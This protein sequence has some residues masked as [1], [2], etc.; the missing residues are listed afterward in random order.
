MSLCFVSAFEIEMHHKF[1]ALKVLWCFMKNK[2]Q[3]VKSQTLNTLTAAAAAV[4]SRIEWRHFGEE[5]LRFCC[6]LVQGLAA[7]EEPGV[8]ALRERVVHGHCALE[9]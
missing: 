5:F 7:C 1:Y 6:W 2:S 3:A 8:V 4:T 9:W